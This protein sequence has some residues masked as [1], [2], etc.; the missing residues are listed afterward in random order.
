MTTLSETFK[1]DLPSALKLLVRYGPKY[2]S[3]PELVHMIDGL[4]RN[5]YHCLGEQVYRKR[6]R[7]FWDFHKKKLAE[8]GYPLNK[9][10]LAA[11]AARFLLKFVVSPKRVR[12]TVR[13][14]LGQ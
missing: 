9:A 8:L 2:L 12:S 1:T 11:A 13:R 10:R 14:R 7:K 3:E 5:Y 6:D 4:L